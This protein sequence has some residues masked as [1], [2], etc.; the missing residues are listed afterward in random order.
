[1]CPADKEFSTYNVRRTLYFMHRDE[2]LRKQQP[3][4]NEQGQRRQPDPLNRPTPRQQ[5]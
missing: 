5:Q 4:N 1:M 3:R 2:R